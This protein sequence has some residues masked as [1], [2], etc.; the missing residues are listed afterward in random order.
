M[1][2][3]NACIYTGADEGDP[4]EF[5][6]S[7][8][9]TARKDHK[10]CECHAVIPPKTKYERTVGKWDGDMNHYETCLPCA[11][12]REAFCCDGWV[13]GQL[14]EDAVNGEFFEHM[15]T[16]CL[17]KLM[18]AEAKTFLIARWNEWKFDK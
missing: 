12:I 13:Y 3:C 8:V 6:K 18:T 1:S 17:E 2:D 14:W 4:P 15:T 11:E 9:V 16:G 10:C 5:L 7:T